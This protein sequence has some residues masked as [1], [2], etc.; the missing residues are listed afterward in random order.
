[1]EE[2]HIRN[3]EKNTLDKIFL[4]LLL[5]IL[6]EFLKSKHRDKEYRGNSCEELRRR[7][8]LKGEGVQNWLLEVLIYLNLREEERKS[9]ENKKNNVHYIIFYFSLYFK[10]SNIYNIRNNSI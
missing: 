9:E 10:I 4:C 6:L 5:Q 2:S 7:A 1:M 3:P 8:R